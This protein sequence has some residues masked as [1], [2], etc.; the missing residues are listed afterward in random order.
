MGSQL[1]LKHAPSAVLVWARVLVWDA[2]VAG[3]LYHAPALSGYGCGVSRSGAYHR[4]SLLCGY[5]ISRMMGMFSRILAHQRNVA[6][7]TF[8]WSIPHLEEIRGSGIC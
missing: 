3:G 4:H 5:E 1:V 6:F 7:A 8:L 2:R